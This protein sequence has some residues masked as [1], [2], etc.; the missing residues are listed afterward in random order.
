MSPERLMTRQIGAVE[1]LFLAYSEAN[2]MTFALVAAFDRELPKGALISALR[3]VQAVHPCLQVSID[4]GG[5][6][7]LGFFRC[8]RPIDLQVKTVRYIDHEQEIADALVNHLDAAQGPLMRLSAISDGERTCVIGVWHHAIADGKGALN[9]L[10]QL[11]EVIHGEPAPTSVEHDYIDRYV[12]DSLPELFRTA[13]ISPSDNRRPM[14]LINEISSSV[15]A[16]LLDLVK[17]HQSTLNSLLVAAVAQ[18]HQH[19]IGDAAANI[20][21]PVDV[22]SFFGTEDNDGVF[23]TTAV[24]ARLEG[25]DIWSHASRVADAARSA[26]DPKAVGGFVSAIGSRFSAAGNYDAARDQ[27]VMQ[28]PFDTIVTN[29]GVIEWLQYPPTSRARIYGPI[30]KPL[31][32]HDIIAASTFAGRLTLIQSSVNGDSALLRRAVSLLEGLI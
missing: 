28:G 9:I 30:V 24:T 19:P 32:G 23:L 2:A 11:V 25:E 29:L 14:I 22:R 21:T 31:P 12:A 7:R 16:S 17:R 20:M 15:T 3:T 1:N 8:D 5:D 26:R 27:I 13:I 10:K 18:A 4:I 6:G